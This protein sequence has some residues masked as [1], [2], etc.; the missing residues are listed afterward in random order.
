MPGA[1]LERG[2][3]LNNVMNNWKT[4]QRQS[5]EQEEEAEAGNYVNSVKDL[6]ENKKQNFVGPKR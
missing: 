6:C 4:K 2:R 5:E 3:R 1:E